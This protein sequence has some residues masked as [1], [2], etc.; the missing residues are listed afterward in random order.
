MAAWRR[1]M[2]TAED[3]LAATESLVAS[4]AEE[5]EQT[6]GIDR[7]Q[8]MFYSLVT[9]AATTFGAESARAMGAPVPAL[10]DWMPT[11]APLRSLLQPPVVPPLALGNGEAPALQFQAYPGGT[12]ALMEK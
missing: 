2:S 12:G 11:E 6:S 9:A 4:M 10:D 8:F 7:R 5:L 3:R 1:C